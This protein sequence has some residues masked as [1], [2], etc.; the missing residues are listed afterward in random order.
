MATQITVAVGA[1]GEVLAAASMRQGARA[2]RLDTEATLKQA[3]QA[4]FETADDDAR[5]G[6]PK[7]Q[8]RQKQ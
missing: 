8:V 1:N 6:Q 3:K 5:A 7:R 4:A 2:D